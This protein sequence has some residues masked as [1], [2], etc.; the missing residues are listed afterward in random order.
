M[1]QDRLAY[2][3]GANVRIVK[4]PFSYDVITDLASFIINGVISTI[5]RL[6]FG[7]TAAFI[8]DIISSMGLPIISILFDAKT[9]LVEPP[10]G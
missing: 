5:I 8:V 4:K 6:V 9:L 7:G 1:Q 2:L 10:R 3:E